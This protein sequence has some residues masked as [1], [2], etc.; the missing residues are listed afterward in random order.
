[1]YKQIEQTIRKFIAEADKIPDS[2]KQVLDSLKKYI[3]RKL[4]DKEIAHLIFIC[5]HNSRR[6]H[7]AQVWGSTAAKYF[8][9]ADRI[10]SYSGGTEETA[11]HPNA[12]GALETL[13]FKIGKPMGPNPKYEVRID[14]DMAP[15]VCY[16]KVFDHPEN[17][18]S[19]F[20]A[21]MTCSEADANCPFI[22]GADI[23]ISLPYDDPKESDGTPEQSEVYLRRSEEI[24]REMVYL[25]SRIAV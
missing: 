16:S 15:L 17:P 6:S 18:Q 20:A 22:P 11:F 10:K 23:R 21:V 2:R 3:E 8:G 5:T 19:G 9:F 14:D 25:I 12:I 1:M 7:L 4:K 24:G 13:G